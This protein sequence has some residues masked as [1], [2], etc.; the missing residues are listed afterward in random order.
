MSDHAVALGDFSFKSLYIKKISPC[1]GYEFRYSC[2]PQPVPPQD[3]RPEGCFALRVHPSP[4]ERHF[5]K[6]SPS[7]TSGGASLIAAGTWGWP[8][9]GCTL[10]A[11]RLRLISVHEVSNDSSAPLGL[12]TAGRVSTLFFFYFWGGGRK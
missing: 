11:T 9:C 3:T 2:Q 6:R 7:L 10:P 5:G 8:P 12:L 1:L 4:A